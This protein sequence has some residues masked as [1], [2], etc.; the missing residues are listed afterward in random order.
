MERA[1]RRSADVAGRIGGDEFVVALQR[2][3]PEDAHMAEVAAEL[4]QALCQPI[5]LDDGQV[6]HVG[7]S[8][9]IACFPQHGSARRELAQRAD[10]ALYAVKRAGKNA[11]AMAMADVET[12]F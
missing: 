9:G 8:I 1:A 4:V 2:C 10:E 3:G 5:P 12:V 6:A 11:Y 7:A